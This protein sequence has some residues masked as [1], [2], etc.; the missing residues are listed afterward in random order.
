MIRS[1]ILEGIKNTPLVRLGKK[2]DSKLSTHGL[3]YLNPSGSLKDRI[4]LKMIDE[5]EREGS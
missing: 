1:R 4:A 2:R 5:A 3:E